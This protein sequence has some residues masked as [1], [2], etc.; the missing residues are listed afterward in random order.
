MSEDY[1]LFRAKIRYL[2]ESM[3]ETNF[4][5]IC[6]VTKHKTRYLLGT[7]IVGDSGFK[8]EI[9]RVLGRYEELRARKFQDEIKEFYDSLDKKI[10]KGRDHV[11]C[12]YE[13]M[14]ELIAPSARTPA[15][16]RFAKSLTPS[17]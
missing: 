1:P 10:L 15:Q 5:K 16:Q 8:D 17:D 9:E 11:S 12:D 7:R 2:I 4:Y 3:G 14:D 13:T 6:R